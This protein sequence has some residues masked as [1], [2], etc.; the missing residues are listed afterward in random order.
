[1]SES[2]E[3]VNETLFVNGRPRI[4][5]HYEGEIQPWD[6]IRDWGLDFWEGNA[7]KY[8]CRA[9]RKDGNSRAQDIRKAIE[10]LKE[11]YQ[12]CLEGQVND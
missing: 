11:V 3:I 2:S 8:I 1:M 10:N 12:Q 9:G 7:L 4:P 5:F 6:V